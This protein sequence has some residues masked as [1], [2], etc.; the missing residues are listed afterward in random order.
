VFKTR[1]VSPL[2][3]FRS[4]WKYAKY[5]AKRHPKVT[6]DEKAVEVVIRLE[7]EASSKEAGGLG[8]SLTV[9]T[10]G[11][12]SR[13]SVVAVEGEEAVSPLHVITSNTSPLFCIQEGIVNIAR[14][15]PAHLEAPKMSTPQMVREGI[16]GQDYFFTPRTRSSEHPRVQRAGEV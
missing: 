1:L 7:E 4:M 16:A 5:F 2:I 3:A 14:P 10:I 15:E 9:R 13:R 8:R 6:E 12:A 11:T